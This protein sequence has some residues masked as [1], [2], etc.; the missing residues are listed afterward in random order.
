[1]T[2]GEDAKSISSSQ[3]QERRRIMGTVGIIGE[4]FIGRCLIIKW[5]PQPGKQ[6]VM[7]IGSSEHYSCIKH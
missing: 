3:S 5:L 1:M 4:P 7:V 6:I 2:R